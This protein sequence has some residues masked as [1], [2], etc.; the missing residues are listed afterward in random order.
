MRTTQKWLIGVASV[1]VAITV[2]VYFFDWNLLRGFVER[3]VSQATGRPLTIAGDLDVK[4]AWQPRVIVN[5]VTFGNASWGSTPTMAQLPHA[6]I[7]FD[8][9]SL[10]THTIKIPLLRVIE[11]NVV[12]EKNEMGTSNWIFSDDAAKS[13]RT[14]SLQRIDID[15][16]QLT[17]RSP[18]DKIDMKIEVSSQPDPDPSERRLH[19]A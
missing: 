14:V 1:V 5:E 6:E 8:I 13:K 2:L 17:Y 12:L 4:L 19:I 7:T 16:G 9:P 10:F 11:P 18:L 15:H 3:R